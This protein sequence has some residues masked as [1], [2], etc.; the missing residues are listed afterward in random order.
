MTGFGRGERSG[1][2]RTWS[3][4]LRS[5]NHRNLDIKVKMPWRFGV[6]EER[7]KKEIA[8]YHSRG[9]VDIYVLVSDEAVEG[10]RL[11]ADLG[12]AREYR[13]CLRR[14]K[15]ELSLKGEPDLAMVSSFRDI[16]TPAEKGLSPEDIENI[17]PDLR[18]ALT[19]AIMDGLA[20][21]ESEGA[22]LK[23]DLSARLRGFAETVK[24]IDARLPELMTKRETALKERLDT[25]LRGIDIDPARLAQEAAILVDKADIT[26]ELVRLRSHIDQFTGFLDSSE[27]CGRKLDFLLQE[28]LREVNT[29]ASK[30]ANADTAYQVVDLKN[31]LEKMREQVQNLE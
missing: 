29:I 26:E 15:E 1:S 3:I 6:F 28:F 16:I 24:G 30:S 17:W 31:E 21:R 7:I 19:V 9:H 20:M 5:V 8:L 4:E 23:N 27:P 2:G 13:D 18:A 22:A 11:K 12:L 25:L 10:Q 14:I